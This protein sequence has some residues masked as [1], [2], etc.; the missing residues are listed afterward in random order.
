MANELK[1]LKINNQ[2]VKQKCLGYNDKYNEV[3]S[4]YTCK[5]VLVYAVEPTRLNDFS[6]D[7]ESI[8][9]SYVP[10]CTFT[11]NYMDANLYSWLIQQVNTK[12]F[13]VEYYDYELMM[14][15]KRK[16]YMSNNELD[17]FH[18]IGADLK[19]LINVSMTFV[20]FYGYSSY[21]E[22]KIKTLENSEV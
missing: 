3:Y 19:G 9:T 10:Q 14:D 11:F 18:N 15:V 8:E 6:L 5:N 7:S 22:L 17:K 20:S 13:Y 1:Y 2:E 4:G 16:M 12:S 21:D